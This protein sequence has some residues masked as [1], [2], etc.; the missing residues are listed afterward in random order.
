MD[1]L[2]NQIASQQHVDRTHARKSKMR[3]TL[4]F[5]HFDPAQDGDLTSRTRGHH[6]PLAL[7]KVGEG[8]SESGA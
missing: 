3:S 6:T 2:D 8:A 1:A 5:R 7:L 4:C